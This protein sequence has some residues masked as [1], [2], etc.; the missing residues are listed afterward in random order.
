VF[1][2]SKGWQAQKK[3]FFDRIVD[4]P[5]EYSYPDHDATLQIEAVAH[6]LKPQIQLKDL[7]VPSYKPVTKKGQ[8]GGTPPP[9]RGPTELAIL[10][11]DQLGTYDDPLR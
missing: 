4:R 2:N 11:L 6:G 9:I 8:A 7:V 1:S 3:W 10:Q 5:R